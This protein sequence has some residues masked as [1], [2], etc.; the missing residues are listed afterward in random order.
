M[1]PSQVELQLVWAILGSES[2]AIPKP[3]A[4][5][6]YSSFKGPHPP[7]RRPKIF[8]KAFEMN[9]FP[10]DFYTAL[11][12]ENLPKYFWLIF[13]WFGVLGE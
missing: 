3:A 8:I 2:L 12:K 9:G 5:G 11:I 1:L 13:T 10:N 6:N 7:F 4:W